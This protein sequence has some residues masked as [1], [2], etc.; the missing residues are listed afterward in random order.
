MTERLRVSCE[1]EFDIVVPVPASFS[2]FK[3]RLFNP[4]GELAREIARAFQI[5]VD[6]SLLKIK[7]EIHKQ[8][9]LPFKERFSNVKGAFEISEPSR[10]KGLH[11]LIVDDVSTSTATLR[12]CSR[13][14]LRAGAQ[15]ITAV[16]AFRA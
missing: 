8:S 3:K 12:E 16:S 10:I 14:L 11:I 7:K 13:T 1:D 9:D 15:R 6:L 2:S 4:A 5:P